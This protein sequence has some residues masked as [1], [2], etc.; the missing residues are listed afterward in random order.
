LD[1]RI[2]RSV[3]ASDHEDMMDRSIGRS[4]TASDHDDVMDR[5]TP[6]GLTVA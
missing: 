3:T 6:I 5:C 4:V 2:G 1:R